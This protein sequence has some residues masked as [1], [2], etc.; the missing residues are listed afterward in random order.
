MNSFLPEKLLDVL[1]ISVTFSVILMALVQK[2]KELSFMKKTSHIW[3]TNLV[4]AFL[5]GIPFTKYFFG[6]NLINSCWICLFSFIGAPAI[7]QTLKKQTMINYSP[8]S[9]AEQQRVISI[10]S[11]NYIKRG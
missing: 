7:Y 11:E 9:L 4:L 3:I 1:I 10:P 8:K 5:L 2:L 6:Q